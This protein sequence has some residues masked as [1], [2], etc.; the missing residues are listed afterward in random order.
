MMES[1]FPIAQGISKVLGTLCQ[2]PG[3][4]TKYTCILLHHLLTLLPD[5]PAL[6]LVTFLVYYKQY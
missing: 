1:R 2:E 4:S 6:T 3:T 5:Y